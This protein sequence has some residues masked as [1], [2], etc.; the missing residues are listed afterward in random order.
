MICVAGRGGSGKEKEQKVR[1][2]TR[3]IWKNDDNNKAS[4]GGACPNYQH[5]ESR[6]RYMRC[7]LK[8]INNIIKT[9]NNEMHILT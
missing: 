2:E 6:G 5:W 3:A 4:Y 9:L 1:K 7:Y 8:K